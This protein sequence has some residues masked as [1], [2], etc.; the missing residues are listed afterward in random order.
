MHGPSPWESSNGGADAIAQRGGGGAAAADLSG[1]ERLWI[2]GV[3]A[4][5]SLAPDTQFDANND[6]ILAWDD[7]SGDAIRLLPGSGNGIGQVPWAAAGGADDAAKAVSVISFNGFASH[8]TAMAGM[9]RAAWTIA[10]RLHFGNSASGLGRFIGVNSTSWGSWH[11]AYIYATNKIEIRSPGSGDGKL[12]FVSVFPLDSPV[13]IISRYD[14][15]TH[16]GAVYDK[17]GVLVEALDTT[18]SGVVRE[19]NAFAM[20]AT[21]ENRLMDAKKMVFYDRFMDAATAAALAANML[22]D[23]IP[24]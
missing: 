24:A 2:A 5:K 8:A 17:D 7:L 4:F 19:S 23:D 13:T 9:S 6:A 1:F 22:T 12:A 15:T 20:Q 21:A 11:I 3:G 16:F 14:G 18:H 10:L